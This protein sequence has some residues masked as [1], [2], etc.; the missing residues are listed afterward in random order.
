M[1]R[2]ATN[3]EGSS[4]VGACQKWVPAVLILTPSPPLSRKVLFRT[5]VLKRLENGSFSPQ[6]GP[7]HG[8]MASET[9]H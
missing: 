6:T 1:D 9:P 7:P 4:A 8:I 2:L 3:R 5:F